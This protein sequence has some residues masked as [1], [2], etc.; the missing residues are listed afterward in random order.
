MTVFYIIVISIAG[1]LVLWQVV[2]RAGRKL[3]RF[4]APAFIGRW[5]D[6]DFRRSMQKT[7]HIIRRSGFK[8]GMK[9]MEI[10]CGSGAYT[11][12]VADAVG[13]KGKVY[14]LDI[15]QKM[16]DQ[17]KR[18]IEQGGKKYGKNIELIRASAYKIPLKN[19]SLDL[20]YMI[21]VLPEIPDRQKVLAEAMRILKP[22]G[23]IAISEFF[24][25]PD[26]PLMTTTK[27]DLEKAG[28][29]IEAVEGNFWSYTVRA[30]K[31]QYSVKR[32]NKPIA[33]KRNRTAKP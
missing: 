33:R 29:T 21:T 9:V 13:T 6:S 10:G 31:L 4:P 25:D 1:L 15:Q 8:P 28:F 16:L 11:L 30:R 32:Q 2:I 12:F 14:A 3:I 22:K 26:Y 20:A 23:I 18:K 24:P 19:N 7:E 17:I 27:R 5:L